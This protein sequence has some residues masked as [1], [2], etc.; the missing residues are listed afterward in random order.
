MQNIYVID[1]FY[2]KFKDRLLLNEKD[3]D[4]CVDRLISYL[5]LKEQYERYLMKLDGNEF[6]I[7]QYNDDL[8]EPSWLLHKRKK[9]S[10]VVLAVDGQAQIGPLGCADDRQV[11]GPFAECGRAAK[12]EA[13]VRF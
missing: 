3:I 5:K 8:E 12:R 7:E 1:K 6:Q 4:Q 11:I 2:R 9:G 10:R 13:L